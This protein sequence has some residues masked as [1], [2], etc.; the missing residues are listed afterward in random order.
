[1]A[2]TYSNLGI[3]L[4]GTGEQAG[5]WGTTTNNNLGTLIDQAISGY[6]TQAVTT[7]GLV[8]LLMPNG[9]NSVGRNMYIQLTGTGGE[10]TVV[11]FPAGKNKLFFIWNNSSGEVQVK[12]A[13]AGSVG[14]VLSAGTRAALVSN[15]TEVYM[16]VNNVVPSKGIILWYDSLANLPSGWVVC[17]GSNGTPSLTSPTLGVYYVMKL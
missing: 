6:I 3:E 1:M 13:A 17:D 12:S 2:S 7:G 4:V 9:S 14:V 11:T 10:D 15:G 16:A 8:A 5:S